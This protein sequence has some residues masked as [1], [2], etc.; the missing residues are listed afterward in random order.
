[1]TYIN[2]YFLFFLLFF[3]FSKPSTQILIFIYILKMRFLLQ[4]TNWE[5]AVRQTTNS[6]PL[7]EIICGYYLI[8]HFCSIYSFTSLKFSHFRVSGS[9]YSFFPLPVL[10]FVILSTL[11][12][13]SYLTYFSLKHLILFFL[14]T[15]HLL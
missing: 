4:R 9:I 10:I 11:I 15:P 1:M 3:F 2:P 5:N 7:H 12:F 14:F 6:I 8:R 13:Y